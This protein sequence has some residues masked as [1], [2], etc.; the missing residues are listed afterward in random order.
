MTRK[1]KPLNKPLAAFL[2]L[3]QQHPPI[4]GHRVDDCTD[5]HFRDRRPA[6]QINNLARKAERKLALEEGYDLAAVV[7]RNREGTIAGPDARGA[8]AYL[9]ACVEAGV[10]AVWKTGK[11]PTVIKGKPAEGGGVGEGGGATGGDGGGDG[12]GEAT[13]TTGGGDPRSDAEKRAFEALKDAF[14]TEAKVSAEQM[15]EIMDK[16]AEVAKQHAT[17]SVEVTLPDREEPKKI[18][19]AHEAFQRVLH[20]CSRHGRALM[21]GPAGTG[22]STIFYHVADALDYEAHEVGLVSCT[23]ETSI[24]DLLGARDANGVYYPGPV[25]RA[26]ENGGAILLD[27]FDALDPGTGVALNA[28]LDGTGRCSVPLRTD[29]PVAER[30]DRFMPI[31]AMNT[32]GGVTHEYTGRGGKQDAATMSRFPWITRAKVD[33]DRKIEKAILSDEPDLA[34]YL[35]NLRDIG[36]KADWDQDYIPT[37]RDFASMALEVAYGSTAEEIKAWHTE[38]WPEEMLARI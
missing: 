6:T 18:E 14:A 29:K 37:T 20:I 2:D 23:A 3:E 22:K 5:Q 7:A 12:G 21:H 34:D 33:Y 27:E 10:D 1:T 32:L 13:T 26:F 8:K 28:A 9:D 15:Q 19:G 4:H 24:Y 16:A 30:H 25:L 17:S 31:I 11:R 36:Q 35:W 38:C